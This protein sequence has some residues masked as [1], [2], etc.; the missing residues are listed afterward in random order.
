MMS[1]GVAAMRSPSTRGA[2]DLADAL[3]RDAECR[4]WLCTGIDLHGYGP[5]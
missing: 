3:A 4:P 1:Y 2:V 5:V